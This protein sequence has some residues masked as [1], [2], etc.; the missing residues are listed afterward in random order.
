LSAELDNEPKKGRE[1]FSTEA[2]E[3]TKAVS[4]KE[5]LLG[6]VASALIAPTVEQLV[7]PHTDTGFF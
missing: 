3:R 5:A 2:S 6:D 7:K 1:G 4:G